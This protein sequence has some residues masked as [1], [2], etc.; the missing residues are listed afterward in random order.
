LFGWASCLYA[1]ASIEDANEADFVLKNKGL[2]LYNTFYQK[3]TGQVEVYYDSLE[4]GKLVGGKA[5]F[6]LPSVQSFQSTVET[7]S[8]WNYETIINNGPSNNR[9]DLV[10]IGD[11]FALSEQNKYKQNVNNILGGYFTQ[12]P[13]AAYINFFNVHRVDIISSDS[14]VDEPDI[15]IYR[16]T[17]LDMT[18]NC[19][20]ITRLLCI[21]TVKAWS[22]AGTAPGADQ[23]IALANSTRYGGA[24][25]SSLV[26]A[27][28]ENS[29]STEIILHELG[30]SFGGLA[31]EYDGDGTKTYIGLEPSQVNISIYNAQ[32]QANLQTKWFRW[33]DLANVDTY[34][35][36]NSS[37]YGIFRPTYDSKMRTLGRPY[38]QVNA[39]QLILKIYG[40]V[41]VIDDATP[42]SSEL[43]S[44]YTSFYVVPV[45]PIPDTIKIQWYI[46]GL[47]VKDAV[48]TTF[49]ANLDELTNGVHQISVTVSDN[50]SMVRNEFQRAQ[51]MTKSLQWQI[52]VERQAI[53]DIAMDFIEFAILSNHWLGNCSGPDWCDN[54]DLNYSGR[55]DFDDLAIFLEDW[56]LK[57][58]SADFD[59]NGAVV[60]TDFAFLA[61]Q[62]RNINCISPDWCGNTDLDMNGK[63]DS[64]DLQFFVQHWLEDLEP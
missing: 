7:S 45:R 63:V 14:G 61:A 18:Y 37:R 58:M 42:L 20:G 8:L 5:E 55:V 47:P 52:N 59:K 17:A 56:R 48:A 29:S 33:L 60:F 24:G 44:A 9:V 23:I 3:N 10:F 39:E 53:Q 62:W 43:V 57:Q 11:G 32:Q 6:A 15:G 21:D 25:Y 54:I 13:L 40:R 41:S 2:E 26:T 22:A 46:D 30:H 16:N 28:S 49:K 31:D 12:A 50:T 1:G 51:L 27:A 35:G 4:E 64:I 34:E 38:E 19:N 36:A